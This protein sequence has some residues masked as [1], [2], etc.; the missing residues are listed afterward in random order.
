V[1]AGLRSPVY[2]L[3]GAPGLV[4]SVRAALQASSV[5]EADVRFEHFWGYEGEAP[6]PG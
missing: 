1:A 2:Y 4:E 6:A 3:C 5:P